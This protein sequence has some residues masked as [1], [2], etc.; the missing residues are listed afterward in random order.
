MSKTIK[1][2]T[3]F[4]KISSSKKTRKNVKTPSAGPLFKISSSLKQEYIDKVKKQRQSHADK[5]ILIPESPSPTPS[6]SPIPPSQVSEQSVDLLLSDNFDD[7]FKYLSENANKPPPSLPPDNASLP[8]KIDSFPY[9]CLSGGVKPTYKKYKKINEATASPSPSPSPKPEIDEE[10]IIDELK[11]IE[12]SKIFGPSKPNQRNLTLGRSRLH[13]KISVLI[14]NKDTRSRI[15]T[16]ETVLK[17][18]SVHEAKKYLRKRNL[19]KFGSFI[20][21]DLAKQ[22]YESVMLTGDVT[23]TNKSHLLDKFLNDPV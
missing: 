13:R 2:N 10:A 21:D 12:D 18:K 8:Y 23:N 16:A 9:G 7:C 5:S 20:P 15:K 22:M 11:P 17:S 14:K 6:L 4:F 19:V 3:D 1:I